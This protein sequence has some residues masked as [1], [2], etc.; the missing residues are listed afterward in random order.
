MLFA[1]QCGPTWMW[2]HFRLKLQNSPKLPHIHRC[3]EILDQKTQT[4]DLRPQTSDPSKQK[5]LNSCCA[6]FIGN[7]KERSEIF[8]F[9]S[10]SLLRWSSSEEL[11]TLKTQTP[12][13]QTRKFRPL[14]IKNIYIF[15]L[16]SILITWNAMH[17]RR[18]WTRN[19]HRQQSC[20][21][22]AICLSSPV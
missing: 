6:K 21:K 15:N 20:P 8:I 1:L 10:L 7:S 2:R 4:L 9:F 18:L 12:K 16:I 13:T 17:D 22:G 11:S 3:H 5:K 19:V 14:E